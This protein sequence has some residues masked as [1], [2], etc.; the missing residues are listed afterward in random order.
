MAFHISWQSLSFFNAISYHGQ[1]W[2]D[3]VTG[4]ARLFLPFNVKRTYVCN[5]F[6]RFIGKSWKLLMWYGS[7]RLVAAFWYSRM[8][9]KGSG[10][11]LFLS[12]NGTREYI[13]YRKNVK[14]ICL[15]NSYFHVRFFTY[16][17]YYLSI[18]CFFGY[19]FH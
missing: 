8:K 4:C 2:I 5:R 9:K 10:K 1:G 13:R 18:L 3:V 11:M 15:R 16:V 6:C 14:S 12:Q 19:Y 17:I 7:R